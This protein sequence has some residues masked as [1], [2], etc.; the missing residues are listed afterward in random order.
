MA[1]N[2]VVASPAAASAVAGAV[3]PVDRVLAVGAARPA[4][5]AE[6]ARR[7]AAGGARPVVAVSG[8]AVSGRV[9]SAVMASSGAQ[10]VARGAGSAREASLAAPVA[11]AGEGVVADAGAGRAAAPVTS[12]GMTASLTAHEFALPQTIKWG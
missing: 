2:A 7:V 10:A 6:R 11:V 5:G 12:R 1:V 4:A 9:A 3:V 8:V